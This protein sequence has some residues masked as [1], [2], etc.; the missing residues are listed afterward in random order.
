MEGASPLDSRLAALAN[1]KRVFDLRHLGDD[2]G[3]LDKRIRCSTSGNDDVL[4][5]RA[6]DQSL[7]DLIDVEPSPSPL[8]R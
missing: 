1:V 5:S 6:I 2:I 7:D 4:S 3:H 8:G